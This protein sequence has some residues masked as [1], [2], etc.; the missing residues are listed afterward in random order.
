MNIA[1]FCYHPV[2]P[3][4]YR[5]V[6]DILKHKHNI[7]FLYIDKERMVSELLNKFGFKSI[8][9][10]NS[11]SNKYTSVFSILFYAIKALH[12]QDIDLIISATS[13]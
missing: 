6:V 8:N 9:L 10:N 2:E 11:S 12:N 4:L 5:H 1:F 13:L 7:I 3:H